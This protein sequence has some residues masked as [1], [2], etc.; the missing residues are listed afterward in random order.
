MTEQVADDLPACSIERSLQVLGER[1]TL[2]VLREVFA[3]RH[4][5]AEIRATLDIAPNLLSARLKTLVAAGVLEA[6]PYQEPGSRQRHS[7]HLTPA[8]WDLRLVLGALQQWGDV[9]RPRTV[10][11]SSSR[12][13]KSGQSVHVAFVNDDG[14]E[15]PTRDVEFVLNK[16]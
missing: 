1:W 4:R 15:V 12:R 14:V 7:Y 6:R 16:P 8:G 10:G 11:P 9:H 3:G 5:F 2:L 13:S